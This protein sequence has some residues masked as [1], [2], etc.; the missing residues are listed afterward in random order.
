MRGS[1]NS[2]TMP[3]PV[4]ERAAEE[5]E[6]SFLR[7]ERIPGLHGDVMLLPAAEVLLPGVIDD[8]AMMPTV[9]TRSSNC[10]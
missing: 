9:R 8:H 1:V 3:A 7:S 5:L 2:E 10:C 4:T 6:A